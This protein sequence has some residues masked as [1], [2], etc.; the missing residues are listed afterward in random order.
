MG[1]QLASKEENKTK[2]I[3]LQILNIGII[4]FLFVCMAISLNLPHT[5]VI[6]AKF[7]T[8]NNL[9]TA[10][11]TSGWYLSLLIPYV[12]T[13]VIMLMSLIVSVY[14]AQKEKNILLPII[15]LAGY[16]TQGIMVMAPY[17]PLRT[18]FT[19]IMFFIIA[20]G[21]L[22]YIS[23]KYKYSILLAFAIP[24]TVINVYLGIALMVI[25]T[26][27]NSLNIDKS[28]NDKI[29]IAIL[30]VFGTVAMFNWFQAYIG[31]KE[32]KA[33]YNENILR[34]ENFVKENP[35]I[36]GQKDKELVLL[37]R[38]DEKYGFT[39]MTGIDW[40]DNAIKNYFDIDISVTLKGQKYNEEN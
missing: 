28:K 1:I 39:A 32:N 9:Y 23:L 38:K 15:L 14:I 34:L 5:E 12:I 2:K 18:T 13:S 20:I 4:I 33:I 8:F 25:Y 10:Y 30:L 7:F 19:T 21:Y 35:I 40:I 11:Y 29:I 17:S 37:L 22:C 36:E 31:Y 24:L 3:I 27:I 26:G 6:K 16:F